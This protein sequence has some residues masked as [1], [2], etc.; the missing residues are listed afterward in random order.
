MDILWPKS[1]YEWGPA[2]LV[3]RV[4]KDNFILD[5]LQPLEPLKPIFEAPS[6]LDNGE[7]LEKGRGAQCLKI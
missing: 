6:L 7:N 3:V 1:H 2:G 5:F 4:V